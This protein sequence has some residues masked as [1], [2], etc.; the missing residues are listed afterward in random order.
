MTTILPK[1]K[2]PGSMIISY[3]T[4]RKILG[5]LGISLVP[6]LIL[7]SFLLDHTNQVQI[8]VSAYYHT[9]MRNVLVGVLC[10]MSLFLLSYHGYE[11]KDSLASKLAGAF[12]LGIAFFP[13]SQTDDKADIISKLHYITSGIFF[14]ILSYMSIFLFTKSSGH[15]TPEKKKRNR[16]Y[17]TCGIIMIISVAGIPVDG[18]K[19]IHDKIIFLKPTLILE[20]LALTSFG[21]SWLTKGEGLLPDK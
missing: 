3:L 15:K 16:I 19:A 10:G 9:H 17:R 13:T 5:L 14:V 20:T 21:I 4:L 1:P 18:I 11:W 12:A 7:G 6:V 2:D 8:S